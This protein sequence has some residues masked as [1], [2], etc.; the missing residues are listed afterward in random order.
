MVQQEIVR[1]ISDKLR[2]KLTPAKKQEMDEAKVED[3]DAYRLY[4]LGRREFDGFAP[5]HFMK[6]AD[7]FRQAIARDPTYAAAHAGLADAS[8]LIGDFVPSMAAT[9]FTTAQAESTEALT[10]DPKSAEA[11]TALGLYDMFTWKFAAAEPEIRRAEELS[12]NFD[13]APEVYSTYLARMGRFNEA[14]DQAQRG[15]A[16]DPLSIANMWEVGWVFAEKRDCPAAIAQMQKTL[17]IDPNYVVA[18]SL[19]GDCYR[20]LGTYD[21]FVESEERV[22][23]GSGQP[24]AAADLKRI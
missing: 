15:L 4:L 18:Y 17:Q 3:P 7:Y 19:M 21:K 8:V 24:E 10:L 11:H 23:Q 20:Q 13:T 6:A 5:E 16:L 2:V 9:A 14:M 12:T 1:D 22:L